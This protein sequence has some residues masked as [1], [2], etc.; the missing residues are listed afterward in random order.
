MTRPLLISGAIGSPYTRKMKALLLYRRI[1]YQFI[2]FNAVKN[3]NLPK[4]PLPLLPGI[5]IPEG[6]DGYRASS[7]ST[8]QLRELEALYSGRS[9]LPTDPA[10]DFLAYLIEDFADEWLT[11]VMFYYRWG[12]AHRPLTSDSTGS[13]PS[14]SRSSPAPWPWPGPRPRA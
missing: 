6:E 10:L 3:R 2:E 12:S 11:K 1:P 5:Y 13:S 14:S 4:T 9:V 8:F 7:D